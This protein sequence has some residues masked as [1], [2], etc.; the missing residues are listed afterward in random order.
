MTSPLSVWMPHGGASPVITP[1]RRCMAVL[2][3]PVNGVIKNAEITWRLSTTLPSTTTR[4]RVRIRNYQ[5]RTETAINTGASFV[6]VY[7][8]QQALDSSGQPT[9]GFTAAPTQAL[10]AFTLPADGSEYISA[11]ITGTQ[12]TAGLP[13]LFSF[14]YTGGDTVTGQGSSQGQ[15]WYKIGAGSSAAVNQTDATGFTSTGASPFD[16]RIEYDTVTTN[17]VTL[18]VGDSITFGTASA[19]LPQQ[20]AYP[21][22]YAL[23]TGNPALNGGVPGALA[24]EWAGATTLWKY[25]RFDPANVPVDQAIVYIGTND[26]GGNSSVA[27]FK[28]N[29]LAILTN[30]R[31]LGVQRIIVC[32]ITP[33]NLA[34]GLIVKPIAVGAT[35][36]IVDNGALTAGSVQLGE[37]L[38]SETVTLSASPTNN[39]DG[40][41]TYTI[42]ATTKA[43]T[44]GEVVALS[45]E[46]LRLG[47]NAF[48]R[49]LPGGAVA[50]ASFDRAW[51]AT[52]DSA[53]AQS[54]FVQGDQLHPTPGGAARLAELLPA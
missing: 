38:N 52:Y 29:L 48:L 47:Y 6:G 34:H 51:A 36:V 37:N 5:L 16:I 44:V 1:T 4:W 22:I 54:D 8:G 40:T 14:A 28:T 50:S 18:V 23:R 24:S 10:G 2:S 7:H 26:I 20:F 42:T 32:T 17:R 33:R 31:A 46:T 49:G 35:S 19:V 3:T 25:Q 12:I 30:L 13:W 27:T 21:T 39:G 41:Y 15:M 45:Q 53:V 43:H 11:W 9:G